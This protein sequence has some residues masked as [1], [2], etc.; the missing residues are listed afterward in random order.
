M[1]ALT[2]PT[3]DAALAVREADVAVGR[4]LVVVMRDAPAPPALTAFLEVVRQQASRLR[5]D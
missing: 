4:R 5:R 1:P 2:L 3:A